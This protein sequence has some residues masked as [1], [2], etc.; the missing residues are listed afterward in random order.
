MDLSIIVKPILA[1]VRYP[2]FTV[3]ETTTSLLCLTLRLALDNKVTFTSSEQVLT[4]VWK[5]YCS[6]KMD[7]NLD[8]IFLQVFVPLIM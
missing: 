7:L 4:A 2:T 3:V 6:Q 8:L 1:L 5:K